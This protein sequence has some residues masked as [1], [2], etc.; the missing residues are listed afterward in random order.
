[1]GEKKRP[2]AIALDSNLLIPWCSSFIGSRDFM[3][4]QIVCGVR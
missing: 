4:D 3:Y 1:M 2:S